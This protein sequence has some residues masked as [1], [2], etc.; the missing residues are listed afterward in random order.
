MNAEEAK[1]LVSKMRAHE[2][3]KKRT[4]PETLEHELAARR[5]IMR[6]IEQGTADRRSEGPLLTRQRE[7]NEFWRSAGRLLGL[8]K[9]EAHDERD[10]RQN[11]Y[12]EQMDDYLDAERMNTL[13]T[14]S[15]WSDELG[16]RYTLTREAA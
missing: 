13:L 8:D 5:E 4:S 16:A 2:Q 11:D 15:G 14:D 1:R 9:L 10:K 12:I 6:Q 7:E 3:R